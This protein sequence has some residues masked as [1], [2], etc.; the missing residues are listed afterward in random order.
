MANKIITNG[1]FASTG[2]D[3]V[4]GIPTR[5]GLDGLGIES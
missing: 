4:V 2:C 1:N 3:S 5:Y